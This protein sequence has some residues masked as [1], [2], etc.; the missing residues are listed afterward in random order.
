MIKWLQEQYHKFLWFIGFPKDLTISECLA[1]QKKRLGWVWWLFPLF[2]IGITLWGMVKNIWNMKKAA[3]DAKVV[4]G[5]WWWLSPF[6]K[7]IGL[8]FLLAF[9]GWLLWHILTFKLKGGATA[10]SNNGNEKVVNGGSTASP[11]KNSKED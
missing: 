9:E 11:S 2:T 6:L 3:N 8:V 1:T 10:A 5:S 4:L 7:I